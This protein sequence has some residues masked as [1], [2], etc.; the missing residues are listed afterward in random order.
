VQEPTEDE[1][2]QL[3]GALD[4][5]ALNDTALRACGL[6]L[7]TPAE[8]AAM[9]SI[10]LAVRLWRNTELE[11]MHDGSI[12]RVWFERLQAALD[13]DSL[14]RAWERWRSAVDRH[15][16]GVAAQMELLEAFPDA[17]ELPRLEIVRAGMRIGYGI[18]D[19]VMFRMN[20]ATV[21][22]LVP[23]VEDLL[24]KPP[25]DGDWAADL[26]FAVWDPER[27]IEIGEGK[28]S[29]LDLHDALG[30]DAWA[31][32]LPT[33]VEEAVHRLA[34]LHD[35]AGFES[36][37]RVAALTAAGYAP[38]W[39]GTPWWPRTVELMVAHQSET[40]RPFAA[41]DAERL[42]SAPA[43]VSGPC[44]RRRVEMHWSTA[45]ERDAFG[46]FTRERR[47]EAGLSAE[48]DVLLPLWMVL[49]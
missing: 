21:T 34:V 35:L 20:A 14:E 46:A 6:H 23:L 7:E 18:P 48:P 31:E 49:P 47:V 22:F 2:A 12:G 30:L 28:W 9:A 8:L 26:A 15:W 36:A 40:D 37:V 32:E 11:Q 10:G 25:V 33:A 17:S 4:A 1:L 43:T 13:D 39:A 19:D 24:A 5:A 16:E 29:V 38:A 44:A 3:R 45:F 27:E 42:A 41:A